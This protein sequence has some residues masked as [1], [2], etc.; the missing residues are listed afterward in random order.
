M[1]NAAGAPERAPV[2]K[3]TRWVSASLILRAPPLPIDGRAKQDSDTTRRVT[4]TADQI[5][6][7][8]SFF[9]FITPTTQASWVLGPGGDGT[10]VVP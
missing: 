4:T 7:R 8:C 2:V 6:D 1:V 3:P 9:F 5:A 10:V